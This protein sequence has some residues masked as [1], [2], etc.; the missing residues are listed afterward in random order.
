[1]GEDKNVEV[2]GVKLRS[3]FRAWAEIDEN[4]NQWFL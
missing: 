2:A 3:D 4:G 1:M